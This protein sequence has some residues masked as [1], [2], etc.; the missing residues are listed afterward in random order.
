MADNSFYKFAVTT[1][2]LISSLPP[3]LYDQFVSLILA[4]DPEI[5]AR[6]T[7]IVV[8]IITDL[9]MP[10]LLSILNNIPARI[11]AHL[12][13]PIIILIAWLEHLLHMMTWFQ[14]PFP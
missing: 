12:T 8:V 5:Q 1:S 7:D 9:A 13:I 4:F 14:T 10:I 11:T 2:D 3:Y 6:T